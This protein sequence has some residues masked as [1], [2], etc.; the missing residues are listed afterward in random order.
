MVCGILRNQLKAIS[1]RYADRFNQRLMH[2][3]RDQALVGQQVPERSAI[4]TNGIETPY[5]LQRI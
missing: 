2:L 3:I 1:W 5:L 4:R